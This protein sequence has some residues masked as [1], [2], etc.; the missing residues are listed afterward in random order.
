MFSLYFIQKLCVCVCMCIMYVYVKL[1][2]KV[3]MYAQ[4]IIQIF[5]VKLFAE[6]TFVILVYSLWG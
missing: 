3:W 2:H 6:F 5:E 4:M 1:V